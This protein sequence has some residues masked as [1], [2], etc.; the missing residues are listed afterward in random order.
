MKEAY[1]KRFKLDSWE[2][3]DISYWRIVSFRDVCLDNIG[4]LLQ[5]WNAKLFV[6][7]LLSFGQRPEAF[8]KFCRASFIEERKTS[9][10]FLAM[11]D[12][13]ITEAI[14]F[15]KFFLQERRHG[16]QYKGER[17]LIY[18]EFAHAPRGRDTKS[19]F[20]VRKGEVVTHKSPIR[21]KALFSKA[22]FRLHGECLDLSNSE[23][24]ISLGA[25]QADF[26]F[27]KWVLRKKGS[28]IS[29]ELAHMLRECPW[30]ERFILL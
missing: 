27:E 26:P 18:Q 11:F 9:V 5:G 29:I 20:R 1:A 17:E 7:N 16:E 8:K 12:S 19:C 25:L 30:G 10:T 15:F 22:A 2:I 6:N 14:N 28:A 23:A 21:L 3:R 24:G 4:A 13:V